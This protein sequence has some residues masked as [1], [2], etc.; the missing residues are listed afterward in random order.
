MSSASGPR[1]SVIIPVYNVEKYLARCLDSV[2]AQRFPDVEILCID[3]GSTDGSLSLLREYAAK[4][5]R[6][7]VLEQKNSGAS[8]ARNAGLEAAKG[9]WIAFVDSDDEVLPD[10]WTTLLEDAG[11]ADAVCFSAE[12]LREENGR[13]T[14]VDSGYFDVPFQGPRTLTD[15]DLVRLSMTVWDKLFRRAKVEDC[16][17]RFPEGVHFEDNVF[18]LNFFALNRNVHFEPR[19]LYRYIRREGS[20]MDEAFHQKP[21]LAFDLVRILDPI[22]DFWT[23]HALLPQKKTIFERICLERLHFAL[24]IC[25]PWER[26]GIVYAVARLF[27]DWNERPDDPFL[28]DIVDGR[29]SIRLGFFAGKD[30]SLLHLK[31]L[32]RILYIGN[33]HGRK[34]FCL[35]GFILFSWKKHQ[36]H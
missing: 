11:D 35:L 28:Q 32:Q 14:S 12:E 23:S 36:D 5:S 27:H 1:I 18:V 21:G 6:I 34:V 16:A 2:L 26:P 24:E 19:R 7:R 30:I 9:T 29:V 17:L 3:D 22:H 25:L 13:R 4:D 33:V 10:I 8:A 20:V 15:Q 31:P